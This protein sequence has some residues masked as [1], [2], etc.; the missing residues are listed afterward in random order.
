M[1]FATVTIFTILLYVPA[2]KALVNRT[3]SAAGDG[4]RSLFVRRR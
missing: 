2:F 1:G 3:R 4:I